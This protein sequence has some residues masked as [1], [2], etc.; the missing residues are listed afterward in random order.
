MYYDR[1]KI[2]IN[3]NKTES[4]TFTNRRKIDTSSLTLKYDDTSMKTVDC[5]QIAESKWIHF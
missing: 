2:K 1:W 5:I 3:P 4:I